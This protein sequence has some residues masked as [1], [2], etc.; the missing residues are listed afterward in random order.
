VAATSGQYFPV[1]VTIDQPGRALAG[2]TAR[3]SLDVTAPEGLALPLGAVKMEQGR[4]WVYVIK[5]NK[6][7]K[8]EVR[9]G[10]SDG[11]LV[12]VVRGLKGDQVV[13]VSNV[14]LLADGDSVKVTP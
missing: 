2:M 10:L 7:T 4:A 6:A 3:V 5:D 9:L 12:Q 11:R 13:A 8:T 14:S 1:V